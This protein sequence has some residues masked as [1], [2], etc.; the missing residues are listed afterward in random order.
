MLVE[1]RAPDRVNRV[2]GLQHRLLFSRAAAMHEAEVAPVL[3]GH[4]F[5]DD[6]RLA[7]PA[8]AEHHAVVRPLHEGNSF[9]PAPTR[10]SRPPEPRI[11]RAGPFREGRAAQDD[12]PQISI[13][14]P[15]RHRARHPAAAEI[16]LRS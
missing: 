15:S 8:R 7:V 4:Q 12:N 1:A 6:A 13:P 2:A 5:E 16:L 3:P 14:V 10:A 9:W 11:T